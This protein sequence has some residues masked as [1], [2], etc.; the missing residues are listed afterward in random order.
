MRL[1]SVK[2]TTT[3][4]AGEPPGVAAVFAAHGAGLFR[5]AVLLVG[6]RAT[7]EDI[8]QDAF[9]GLQRR[10]PDLRDPGR[11]PAYVRTAVV[12]GA[13]SALRR[14]ALTRRLH[15]SHPPPIWSAESAE[16]AAIVGEDRLEVMRALARLPPRR[17]AV[18]VL[19]YYLDLTDD[20]IADVLGISPSSVRSTASRGLRT[21]SRVF[22][23]EE[24]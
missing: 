14:R 4:V 12:N 7:A 18:L 2:Q 21:L 16:Y 20:E 3:L 8:V 17:R 22:G 5:L 9:V 10:W 23:Q 24:A 19:R 13:N 15:A 6:D 11:A 1:C